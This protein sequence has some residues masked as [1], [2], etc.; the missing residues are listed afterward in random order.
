MTRREGLK[1]E[2]FFFFL[3]LCPGARF[4]SDEARNYHFFCCCYAQNICSSFFV[5]LSLSLSAWWET[6]AVKGEKNF[7]LLF[8]LL[9]FS[10]VQ[11]T[12][13]SIALERS[14]EEVSFLKP[15]PSKQTCGELE[16]LSFLGV[17]LSSS[18]PL[19]FCFLFFSFFFLPFCSLFS[20]FLLLHR[21][22]ERR[23]YSS[24]I[25][26][27]AAFVS[28]SLFVVERKKKV[29]LSQKLVGC[30]LS[31]TYSLLQSFS[32]IRDRN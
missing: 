9:F 27:F 4:F 23:L 3:R 31:S 24:H 26:L 14:E 25:L 21:P 18:F 15:Y 2:T 32:F 12:S 13:R 16:S 28:F 11:Y 22:S 10:L 17:S 6:Y 19:L 29:S 1:K 30:F 5:S 7:F 20:S 8:F